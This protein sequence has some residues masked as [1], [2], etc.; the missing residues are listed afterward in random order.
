MAITMKTA[1]E[2]AQREMRKKFKHFI[3]KKIQL[4][5]SKTIMQKK[6]KKAMRHMGNKY[7]TYRKY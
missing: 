3:E 6:Y 4:N 2:C 5:I 7:K 1:L